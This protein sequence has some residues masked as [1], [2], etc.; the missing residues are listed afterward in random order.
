MPAR[1]VARYKHPFCLWVTLV[2]IPLRTPLNMRKKFPSNGDARNGSIFS[3]P[4]REF[5]TCIQRF[6]DIIEDYTLISEYLF[7]SVSPVNIEIIDI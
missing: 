7:P 3:L 4:R 5:E 6:V 2:V 1:F